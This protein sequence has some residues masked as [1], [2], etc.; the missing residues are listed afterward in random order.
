[1]T[2]TRWT[3]KQVPNNGNGHPTYEYQLVNSLGTIIPVKELNGTDVFAKK[4]QTARPLKLREVNH[5]LFL[6][7]DHKDLQV[8]MPETILYTKD[9]IKSQPH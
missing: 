7:D 1:M 3:V 2:F 9:T 6:E 4:N 8:I 5:D